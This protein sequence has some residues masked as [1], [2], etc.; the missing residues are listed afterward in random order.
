MVKK[1][2]TLR[3]FSKGS[4]P[5]G[6]LGGKGVASIPGEAEIMTIFS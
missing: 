2:M 6:D 5:G 4:K 1:F 3:A